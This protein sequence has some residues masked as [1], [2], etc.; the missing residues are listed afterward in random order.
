M[1]RITVDS[2]VVASQAV[3]SDAARIDEAVGALAQDARNAQL[4]A[5]G[6]AGARRAAL[7]VELEG[8]A[9]RVQ[10]LRQGL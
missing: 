5:D 3:A 9:D 8:L 2:C 1:P 6:E 4:A 7:L 10:A